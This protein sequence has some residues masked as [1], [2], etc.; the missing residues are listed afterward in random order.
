MENK[1][2]KTIEKYNMIKNG[3]SIVVGLSGGADSCALLHYLVSIREKLSLNIIACHVNHM[4]RGEEADRDERFSKAFCDNLGVE[5][6]ILKINVPELA[7]L[8]HESTEKCARDIRYEF[9]IKTA[10]ECSAKIATAHTASDNAETVIYNLSRGSGI[11]GLCG[12][13]PVRDNIIRPLISVLREDTESYCRKNSIDYVTD[14]T[15][16]TNEY[17]RNKIRLGIIPVLKEINPSVI[18]NISRM[19]DNLRCNVDFLYSFSEEHLKR[20]ED[21]RYKET[22]KAKLLYRCDEAVFAHMIRILTSRYDIIPEMRHIK[23]IRKICQSGGE[24]QINQNVYAVCRQGL[25]RITE[26]RNSEKFSILLSDIKDRIVIKHKKIVLKKIPVSEINNAEKNSDLLFINLLDCDTI[27]YGA[28]LRYREGG[29]MFALPKR[30]VTKPV[31]KLFTEM[32]I[33]AERRDSILLLADGNDILWIDGIG[34]SE[35]YRCKKTTSDVLQI[36]VS[37]ENY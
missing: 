31:K 2:W 23:L 37:D 15:N 1:A 30:G 9:F 4:I 8:R 13:P 6:R 20:C 21:A 10:N 16:L 26:K 36:I 24:V 14:S 19:T 35:K 17:T 32:K 12:I 5:C 28:V 3:D 7:R 33:P 25:F 34:A 22:Y 29:D 18:E 11:S 27:P